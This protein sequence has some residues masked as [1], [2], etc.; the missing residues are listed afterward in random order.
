MKPSMP[1]LKTVV[2]LAAAVT[3]LVG[4]ELKTGTAPLVTH[5]WG[6]FT[7]VA[8]ENGAAVEWAPLLGPGDLPCFVTRAQEI[9]KVALRGLVRMETPVLYFY[10]QQP[11]TLSI[12]V[13]FPQGLITE[14]YPN[15]LPGAPQRQTVRNSANNIEWKQVQVIP[16]TDLSYP[17]T[18]GASHYYAARN[19]DATPLRIGD[20]QEK[21]IFYRGVG[22]FAPPLRARYDSEGQLE[23][24]N[25]GSEAI[26]FAIVF[27]NQ[28]G[29]L[30]F[31]MAENV[32][33]SVTID[34]PELTQDPGA[35][36]GAIRQTLVTRL[37]SLGLYPKE[38]RAMVETWA[39]SWFTE[40]A[41][42]LYI[43]PRATVDS[44]LPLTITPAPTELQRVF[45]GR[46]E[47]LS[48][49]TKDTLQHALRAG[50]SETLTAFGRF[51]EPFFAQIQR[52]DKEF[53]LSPAANTYLRAIA[54]G[55]S[56]TGDAYGNAWETPDPASCV[57]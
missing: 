14:W 2:S 49:R 12:H 18:K 48:P 35:I 50:D 26:P 42:V 56:V 10:A 24:R 34:A 22:A 54:A 37:T 4:A 45:V 44:L 19:T 30:G 29:A 36:R 32:T 7:S 55:H 11:A 15:P 20:Q 1:L 21:M 8:K 52:A 9:R 23:I 6:T 41:R 25:T 57:E 16:G 51:L 46:L 39:D 17:V 31:R 38:A 40:G 5:E 13:D 33:G 47:V 27:E 53:I 28:R 43:V 3:F